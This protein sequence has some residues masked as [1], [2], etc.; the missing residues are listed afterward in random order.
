M[1]LQDYKASTSS[2]AGHMHPTHN[3][4]PTSIVEPSRYCTPP[5]QPTRRHSQHTLLIHRHFAA[6]QHS[7]TALTRSSKKNHASLE[8]SH[9]QHQLAPHMALLS[10]L[11]GCC[12]LCQGK[13][14]VDC[15][16]QLALLRQLAQ[17][18]TAQQ[19]TTLS[20]SLV[21]TRRTLSWAVQRRTTAFSNNKHSVACK[22][23]HVTAVACLHPCRPTCSRP[24]CAW[25]CSR[26]TLYLGPQ[27][28]PPNSLLRAM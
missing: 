23:L 28:T 6:P 7:P 1:K 2:A 22:L 24:L 19:H 13:H 26:T 21:A 17:L 5:Q 12:C 20:A 3:L 8:V 10:L 15:G 14:L 4:D 27:P 11:M 16:L 25:C 18:Q 9:L